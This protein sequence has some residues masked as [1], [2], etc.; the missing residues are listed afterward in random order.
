LFF[1]GSE[2][3]REVRVGD[4]MGDASSLSS[5]HPPHAHA[6]MAFLASGR[7]RDRQKMPSFSPTSGSNWTWRWGEPPPPLMLQAAPVVVVAAALV[8]DED[9]DAACA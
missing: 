3:K 2:G 4:G 5:T 8:A 1:F 7:V 9:D 6:P